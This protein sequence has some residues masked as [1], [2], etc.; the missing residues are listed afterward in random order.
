[1]NQSYPSF[2]EIIEAQKKL[3][4]MQ[5]QEWLNH[6]LYTPQF[7]LLI[8]LMIVPWFIWWRIVRKSRLC[9]ILLYGMFVLTIVTTLDEFGCQLILWEYA[10]D[11]EPLFPRLIPINFTVLPVAYML[12]YQYFETWR[13]YLIANLIMATLFSFVA[14]PILVWIGIYKLYHWEYVYSLPIYVVIAVLVK[15]LIQAIMRVQ[16]ENCV[17]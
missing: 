3:V 13:S 12:I 11:V 1:M 17:K 16:R 4:S 6:D 5:Q 7:W 15:W 2:E 10:Y 8:F 9:E 14:E